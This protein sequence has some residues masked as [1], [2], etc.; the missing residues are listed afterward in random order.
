MEN[1]IVCSNCRAEN[2]SSAK[3]CNSCGSVLKTNLNV[4]DKEEL[5]GKNNFISNY[6]VALIIFCV[7]GFFILIFPPVKLSLASNPFVVVRNE[8]IF[9][10]NATK[11][12]EQYGGDKLIGEINSTLLF[13]ELILLLI[14]SFVLQ[15]VYKK[16]K[17]YFLP[18]DYDTTLTESNKMIPGIK[19]FMI[20]G[21][22]SIILSWYPLSIIISIIFAI[23]AIVKSNKFKKVYNTDPN[24]YKKGT[25]ILIR[26]INIT[27]R[28]GLILSCLFIIIWVVVLSMNL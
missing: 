26:N 4:Q 21:I 1:I 12:I 15:I 22:I 5:Q 2:S 28:I 14:F 16:L 24:K 3:F 8:F 13:I 25:A 18:K 17:I 23:V 20:L 10:L 7:V 6:K 11:P 19:T 9:I 27:G